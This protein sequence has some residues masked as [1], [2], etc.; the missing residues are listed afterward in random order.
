LASFFAAGADFS[1]GGGVDTVG[2]DDG[3]PT[4]SDAAR[5][6]AAPKPAAVTAI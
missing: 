1:I 2:I 5:T 3:V 4:K 6:T